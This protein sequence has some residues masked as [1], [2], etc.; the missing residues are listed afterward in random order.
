[1]RVIDEWGTKKESPNHGL[2][3]IEGYPGEIEFKTKRQAMD[4]QYRMQ[5]EA[6]EERSTQSEKKAAQ[7]GRGFGSGRTS[8]E[9][10]AKPQKTA[11][12]AFQGGRRGGFGSAQAQNTQNTD[13]TLGGKLLRAANAGSGKFFSAVGQFGNKIVGGLEEAEQY[14]NGGWTS[15]GEYV[16]GD[17]PIVSSLLGWAHGAADSVTEKANAELDRSARNWSGSKAG[18]VF[19]K[20]AVNSVAAIPQAL[21]AFW[22]GGASAAGELGAQAGMLEM[23]L[24][25]LVSNPRFWLTYGQNAGESYAKAK[26][27]GASNSDALASSTFS[28]LTGA[29]IDLGGGYENSG[30]MADRSLNGGQVMKNLGKSVL[31]QSG[32]EYAKGVAGRLAEKSYSP[33]KQWYST[34]DENAVF[35]P[36]RDA[37][38]F[39]ADAATAALVE[40]SGYAARRFFDGASD[41]LQRRGV[42]RKEAESRAREAMET[43]EE[44]IAHEN[45]AN[46]LTH[47][48]YDDR[49]F[50][51]VIEK[52]KQPGIMEIEMDEATEKV[53]SERSF[54]ELQP[55]QGKMSNRATRRW[56]IAQDEKIPSLIDTDL[57]IEE[58]AMLA[59]ELRNQ[60]RTWARDL[61]FD[62]EERKWLDIKYPN[63]SYEELIAQKM[64]KKNYT[65][66]EAI[67]DIYATATK[68]R[69]SVNEKL[70][71]K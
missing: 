26:A 50:S 43:A 5:R 23:A 36:K 54:A 52:A 11:N 67:R 35:N 24:R 13:A 6:A 22:T 70:G 10:R 51:E 59:C 34:K 49:V 71:L 33:D 55:L 46:A 32:E 21:L 30:W 44:S 58:Q 19:N 18:R 65:R 61:M 15:D 31:E 63:Q 57:S 14:L 41:S 2:G 66:E 12:T 39:A 20:V 8:Y 1:M 25:S 45:A 48:D 47:D 4:Y 62:Q 38:Q 3:V 9:S 56:Y 53:I 29:M 64:K 37:R 42:S 60:N 16:K 68:T 28:G 17:S 40:G 27:A 69:K 7:G